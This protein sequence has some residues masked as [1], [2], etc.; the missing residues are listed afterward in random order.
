MS[1]EAS[2]S[3]GVSVKKMEREDKSKWAVN[4]KSSFFEFTLAMPHSYTPICKETK[5]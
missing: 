5:N 3:L 1:R 4:K 2:S